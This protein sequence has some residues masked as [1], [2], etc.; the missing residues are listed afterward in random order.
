[1]KLLSNIEGDELLN[2]YGFQNPRSAYADLIISAVK[3]LSLN[4]YV[5]VEAKFWTLK[6]TPASYVSGYFNPYKKNGFKL[7]CR[8]LK[9]GDYLIKRIS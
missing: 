1:M 8:G 6:S 3:S 7:S 4:S 9:N 5:Q 2:K